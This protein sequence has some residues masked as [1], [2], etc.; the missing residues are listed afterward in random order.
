MIFIVKRLI[1]G[2]IVHKQR[3]KGGIIVLFRGKPEAVEDA[4]GIGIDDEHRLSRCVEDYGIR[5]LLANAINGEE[6][7]TKLVGIEGK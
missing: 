4:V 7:T 5:R 2:Q 3:L 6:L 1:V